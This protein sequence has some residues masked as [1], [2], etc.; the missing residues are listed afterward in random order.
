MVDRLHAPVQPERGQRLF[1]ALAESDGG[2]PQGD[3]EV[4][5]WLG[6][7]GWTCCVGA[8]EGLLEDAAWR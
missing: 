1:L 2:T 4:C 7:M 5:M 3:F 6:F 8:S